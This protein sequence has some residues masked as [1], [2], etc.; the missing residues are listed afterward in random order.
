M[1]QGFEQVRYWCVATVCTSDIVTAVLSVLK[2][3][4]VS[5]VCAQTQEQL[6]Q[7]LTVG[8]QDKVW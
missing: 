1:M 4:S 3:S 7:T 6:V 2:E 5:T 8:A